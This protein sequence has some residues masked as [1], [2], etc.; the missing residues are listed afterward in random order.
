MTSA[1]EI[2]PLQGFYAFRA[3]VQW[4]SILFLNQKINHFRMFT[5]RTCAGEGG[6][7]LKWISTAPLQSDPGARP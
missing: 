3:V 2:P 1:V 6:D 5:K 7:K 4:I